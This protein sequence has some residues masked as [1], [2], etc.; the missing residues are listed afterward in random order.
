VG[1]KSDIHKKR[2]VWNCWRVAGYLLATLNIVL[3]VVFLTRGLDLTDE[4]FYLNWIKDPWEYSFFLTATGFF[5]H[6]LALVFPDDVVA[7]RLVAGVMILGSTFA[8]GC[9]VR[10]YACRWLSEKPTLPVSAVLFLSVTALFFYSFWL[11]S[12]GYNL[13]NFA[14]CL[15]FTSGLLFS[16]GADRRSYGY[17]I[18]SSAGLTSL[19]A[20]AIW[21]ARPSTAFLMALFAMGFLVVNKRREVFV[22]MIWAML[23]TLIFSAAIALVIGGSFEGLIHRYG[24]GFDLISLLRPPFLPS[25]KDQ[26]L[27]AF[28]NFDWF[29]FLG[30]VAIVFLIVQLGCLDRARLRHHMLVAMALVA[31][32]ICIGLKLVADDGGGSVARLIPL[33]TVIAVLVG[34]VFRA[35]KFILAFALI[36]IAVSALVWCGLSCV[37]TMVI[38][39]SLLLALIS[40]TMDDG[41]RAKACWTAL[42]LCWVPI[43][44][45]FGSGNTIDLLGGLASVFWIA[46]VFLVA[47]TLFPTV[48]G[49]LVEWIGVGFVCATFAALVGAASKPYRL[50]HSL[51]VQNECLPIGSSSLPMCLDSASL[52]YF[53][54]IQKAALISGFTKST[55]IID[56]TGTAPS[57]IFYLGGVP[58]GSAW[59]L[60]GYPNSEE[61]TRRALE[62]V[63][64]DQ[65]R[66]A[67]VLTAPNGHRP[68][69]NTVMEAIGL[70]FPSD[71]DEVVRSHTEY[72]NETHIL[73]KPEPK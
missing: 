9:S 72:E 44:F 26:F 56:L 25:I 70:N 65:L 8:L 62:T 14:G 15:L 57:T 45:G 29:F 43:A 46:V 39:A 5:F 48:Q 38:L 68:I 21:M 4:G 20:I 33:S 11:P 2:C 47:M 37:L 64:R 19:G 34:F 50:T 55:P 7:W 69:P 1:A 22:S 30:D 36:L 63:P 16:A 67:W 61:F 24:L 40:R 23:L 18:V 35:S 51:W 52:H 3:F 49:R 73:W 53:R 31:V 32:S 10:S 12:P 28:S 42:L 58:I 13:L 66:R 71:Y 54:R 6:P 60:G 59:L 41:D 17:R 27:Y